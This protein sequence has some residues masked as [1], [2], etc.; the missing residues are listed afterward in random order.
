MLFMPSGGSSIELNRI[1]SGIG[2]GDELAESAGRRGKPGL[3]LSSK[4]HVHGVNIVI[5]RFEIDAMSFERPWPIHHVG[6][7]GDAHAGCHHAANGF[8]GQCTEDNVGDVRRALPVSHGRAFG[9]VNGQHQK[10]LTGKIGQPNT[11]LVQ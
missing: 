3:A 6:Q 2:E 8:H 9:L 1:R 10:R 4:A 11:V 7:N 5:E